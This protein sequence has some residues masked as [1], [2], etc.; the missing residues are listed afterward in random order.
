MPSIAQAESACP[1][2][3]GETTTPRKTEALRLLAE[4]REDLAN[5]DYR[6]RTAIAYA[7]NVGMS[8]RDIAAELGW[9]RTPVRERLARA[10]GEGMLSRPLGSRVSKNGV[11]SMPAA[12]TEAGA[13]DDAAKG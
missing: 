2:N 6:G 13:S 10:A 5:I 1:N 3:A 4:H 12:T 8:E 7:W 11:V 9:S